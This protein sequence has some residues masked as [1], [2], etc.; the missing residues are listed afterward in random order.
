MD[1]WAADRFLPE[2]IASERRT[3]P[4]MLQGV[5]FRLS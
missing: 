2:E 4:S 1:R 3:E 5:R